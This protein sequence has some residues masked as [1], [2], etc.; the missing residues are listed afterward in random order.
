[1]VEVVSVHECHTDPLPNHNRL[2]VGSVVLRLPRVGVVGRVVVLPG[3]KLVLATPVLRSHSLTLRLSVHRQVPVS[4]L[5]GSEV[6]S[7]PYLLL[8]DLLRPYHDLEY[9]YFGLI[10]VVE[11][12]SPPPLLVQSLPVVPVFLHVPEYVPHQLRLM[13]LLSL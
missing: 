7:F 12:N 3:V 6:S 4:V 13:Y 2:P 9:S 5:V 8:V 11:S 1:M 10:P